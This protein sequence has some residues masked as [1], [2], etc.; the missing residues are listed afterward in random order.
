M[1]NIQTHVAHHFDKHLTDIYRSFKIIQKE[2]GGLHKL[3]QFN[4]F[5]SEQLQVANMRNIIIK[6]LNK[7]A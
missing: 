7:S 2:I 5:T 3:T 4:I 1:S 6:I